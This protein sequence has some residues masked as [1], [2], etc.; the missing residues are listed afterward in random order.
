MA[1]TIKIRQPHNKENDLPPPPASLVASGTAPR[2]D[3]GGVTHVRGELKDCSGTVVATGAQL[4]PPP[5][6]SVIFQGIDLGD[7]PPYKIV[8]YDDSPQPTSDPA[9][10]CGL[11]FNDQARAAGGVIPEDGSVGRAGDI[12]IDSPASQT[13]VPCTNFCASGRVILPSLPK[14][15]DPPPLTCP[16]SGMMM[17]GAGNAISGVP[18]A[19]PPAQWVLQ[20]NGLL[21]GVVYTLVVYTTSNSKAIPGLTALCPL[22][23]PLPTMPPSGGR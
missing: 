23:D 8:I 17:D 7:G 21:D 19:A 14:T 18:L 1:T 20:F 2:T 22:P 4:G 16:V 13:T 9:T 10:V 5:K 12:T 11:K 15:G 6:W 3:D